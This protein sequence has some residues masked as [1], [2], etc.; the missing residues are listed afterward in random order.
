M[1]VPSSRHRWRSVVLALPAPI[2]GIAAI[3]AAPAAAAPGPYGL[4]LDPP[5]AVLVS[6]SGSDAT[7]TGTQRSPFRTITKGVLV[8]QAHNQ[9]VYV[10]AGA[11]A[12]SVDAASNVAVIGGFDPATWTL[13]AAQ[14]T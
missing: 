3:A 4:G 2:L 9:N 10:A 6:P 13:S 1:S 14:T 12:E 8:A 11:Y 5:N 7:G